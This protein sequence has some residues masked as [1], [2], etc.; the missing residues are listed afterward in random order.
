MSHRGNTGDKLRVS[1]LWNAERL[2]E[3]VNGDFKRRV[4]IEEESAQT[5]QCFLR[6][7]RSHG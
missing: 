7:G 2:Q 6:E 1:L 4:S 3:I 5:E